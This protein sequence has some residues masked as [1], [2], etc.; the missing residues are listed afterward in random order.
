MSYTGRETL[1]P[2]NLPF[3][4]RLMA[5]TGL[6]PSCFLLYVP[7]PERC[8][9]GFW[10]PLVWRQGR[11]TA[12]WK[13]FSQCGPN[14]LHIA[15]PAV[16]CFEQCDGPNLGFSCDP[17]P[18]LELVGDAGAIGGLIDTDLAS[19]ID[20]RKGSEWKPCWVAVLMLTRNAAGLQRVLH[21]GAAET[22]FLRVSG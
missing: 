12:R 7:V 15:T 16:L 4:L 1:L 6:L 5:A 11:E 13:V 3:M 10:L 20:V 21:F 14:S 18:S 8:D 2:L 9:S 19:W 22:I 17:A